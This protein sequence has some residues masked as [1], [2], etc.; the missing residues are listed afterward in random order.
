ME[1]RLPDQELFWRGE[2][3]VG[4]LVGLVFLVATLISKEKRKCLLGWGWFFIFLLPNTALF[5]RTDRVAEHFLY[6]A[7]L[8]IGI[9]IVPFGVE[10]W[11]FWK[12]NRFGKSVGWI[13]T[14]SLVFYFSFLT[15]H[16]SQVFRDPERF[17]RNILTHVPTSWTA[18]NNLGTLLEK[19]NRWDEAEILLEK[20]IQQ[21]P[22]R[23]ESHS[24]FGTLLLRQGDLDGAIVAYR[25]A[26]RLWPVS[27]EIHNNLASA[28]RLRGAW[29]EAVF[30]YQ[31]A[32]RLNPDLVVSRYFLVKTYEAMGKKR[33][34]EEQIRYLQERGIRVEIRK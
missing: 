6:L 2:I 24:N 32:L 18:L 3:V 26:L 33:L 1:R 31:Q 27:P 12:G 9:V 34:A 4:I 17:Y 29:Q 20:A 5:L 8:G 21:K 13:A 14:A 7:L 16:Q 23:P 28:Y 11:K 25:K 15:Y 10:Q 19:K 30:E 22:H